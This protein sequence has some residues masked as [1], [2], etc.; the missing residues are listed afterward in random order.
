[1]RH[2]SRPP[3]SGG[4]A[5]RELAVDFLESVQQVE[6]SVGRCTQFTDDLAVVRVL[7]ALERP[8]R[9]IYKA[10]ALCDLLPIGV[11]EAKHAV[12][13]RDLILLPVP[14]SPRIRV[15]VASSLPAGSA[16]LPNLY[17]GSGGA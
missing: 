16:H 14:T 7:L 8:P 4:W 13:T 5:S 3:P 17:T 6:D 9:I 12:D 15:A 10:Q 11:G 2:T 1:M